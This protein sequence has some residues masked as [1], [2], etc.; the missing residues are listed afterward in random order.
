MSKKGIYANSRR[1]TTTK[2]SEKTALF[3]AVEL[4]DYDIVKIL[5][6]YKDIDINIIN[7]LYSQGIKYVTTTKL[8]AI[9]FCNFRSF[10]LK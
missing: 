10:T 7:K 4:S 9:N 1:S 2:G 3:I 5:L 6:E 8:T